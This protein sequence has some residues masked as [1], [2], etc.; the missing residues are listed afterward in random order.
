MVDNFDE[1]VLLLLRT[2]GM[3]DAVLT[4]EE[5]TGARHAEATT[6]V[7]KLAQQ[8]G[9][10]HRAG[11]TRKIGGGIG[12]RRNNRSR[13]LS[14]ADAFQLK[15]ACGVFFGFARS[16]KTCAAPSWSPD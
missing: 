7:R 10:D 9:L 5:E 16:P 6:A 3:G 4:Y 13:Q 15:E 12:N 2:S 1:L 11:A 8:H 14:S